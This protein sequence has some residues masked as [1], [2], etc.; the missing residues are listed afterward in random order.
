MLLDKYILRNCQICFQVS[1]EWSHRP[2]CSSGVGFHGAQ[3]R[4]QP[5]RQHRRP[6]RERPVRLPRLQHHRHHVARAS[7]NLYQP[8]L[9]PA[10]HAAL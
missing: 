7:P 6:S 4:H 1:V 5:G 8:E 3:V 10:T 2:G 9:L